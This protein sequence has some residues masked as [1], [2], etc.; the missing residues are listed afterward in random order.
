MITDINTTINTPAALPIHRPDILK[1]DT[2]VFFISFLTLGGMVIDK[3]RDPEI[4]FS[5]PLFLSIDELQAYVDMKK[6]EQNPDV[7]VS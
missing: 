1:D 4:R 6:L 5:R 3:M 2:E 7:K